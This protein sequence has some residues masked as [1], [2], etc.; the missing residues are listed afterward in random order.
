M[1]TSQLFGVLSAGFFSLLSASVSADIIYDNGVA[2]TGG[3]CSGALT[4]RYALA[5]D[6]T[7]SAGAATISDV[8]WVGYYSSVIDVSLDDFV[9][10]FYA[11]V[12]GTPVDSAFAEYSLGSVM[13]TD[14][15]AG[16]YAY[17]AVIPD[18]A[19]LAG[20]QYF[21]SIANNAAALDVGDWFWGSSGLGSGD[22]YYKDTSLS[23]WTPRL[24]DFDFQLTGT[25]EVPVP[26]AVWLFGSG[27]I[28]LAGFARRRA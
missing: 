26:A 25:P 5:D 24:A 10:G 11:S 19:L 27:L 15:G 7:L 20:T 4:C 21:I 28:G 18:L 17:D 1:R 8:H 3:D 14:M 13:R 6:F 16:A 2:S 12:G 23:S 9:I 22:G